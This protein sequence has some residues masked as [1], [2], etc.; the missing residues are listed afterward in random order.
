MIEPGCDAM[1][2]GAF[3]RM[4]VENIDGE[5]EREFGLA[6][7]RLFRF[8]PDAGEQRIGARDPDDPGGQTLRHDE[9][10]NSTDW[11]SFSTA[12]VRGED[13]RGAPCLGLLTGESGTP[14]RACAQSGQSVVCLVTLAPVLLFFVVVVRLLHGRWARGDDHRSGLGRRTADNAARNAANRRADRAAYDCA[15]NRAAGCSGH[16]AV[17]I[18]KGEGWQ[19]MTARAESPMIMPRMISSSIHS[20]TGRN[21]RSKNRSELSLPRC[22]TKRA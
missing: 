19:A 22:K 6:P 17:A 3:E 16:N 9:L 8:L 15:R 20:E 1:R 5:K 21:A 13:R 12:S 2:H 10:P 11:A 4:M 18:S 7:D 14:S